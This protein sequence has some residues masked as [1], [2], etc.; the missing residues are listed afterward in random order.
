MKV[1]IENL[2]DIKIG[3]RLCDNVFKKSIKI[4]GISDNYLLGAVN[5]KGESKYTIWAREPEAIYHGGDGTHI[6]N[7]I[8]E[9]FYFRGPDNTIFGGFDVKEDNPEDY[10][11]KLENGEL[12]ISWKRRVSL[13][14]MY[15]FIW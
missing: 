9:R 13:L 3:D 11:K 10:L 12:E 6:S 2:N 8:G 7:K 4:V 14:E 15:K 5:V 1:R